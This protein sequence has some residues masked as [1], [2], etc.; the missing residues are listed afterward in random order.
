MLHSAHRR[1]LYYVTSTAP[2]LQTAAAA[3]E[4]GEP[5][6]WAAWTVGQ[7]RYLVKYDLATR[8]VVAKFGTCGGFVYDVRSCPYDAGK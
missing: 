2:R 8:A 7:D 6:R 3:S 5:P 4:P 1:G